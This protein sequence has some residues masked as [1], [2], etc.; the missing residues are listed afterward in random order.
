MAMP[1]LQLNKE[2]PVEQR[3]AALEAHFQHMHADMSEIKTD[4]RRIDQKLTG[5]IDG[6]QGSVTELCLRIE[7][8]K[9]WAI[10]LYI[11]GMGGLLFVMARGFKW[12]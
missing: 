1:A 9:L 8:F 11:G 4:L 10:L 2:I 3:V 5:R 6:V 7:R 12:L